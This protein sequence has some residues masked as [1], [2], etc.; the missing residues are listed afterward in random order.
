MD[1]VQLD[2]FVCCVANHLWRLRRILA[3]QGSE[4]KWERNV[5]AMQDALS[6][7]GVLVKDHDGENYDVGMAVNVVAWEKRSGATREEILETLKPTIRWN[8]RL[9]QWGDVIVCMPDTREQKSRE[10]EGEGK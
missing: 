10:V 3:E 6:A 1:A 7:I 5:D 8:D 2:R 9:L 4:L